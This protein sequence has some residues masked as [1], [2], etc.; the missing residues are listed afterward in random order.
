MATAILRRMDGRKL[1]I[2]YTLNRIKK[3][4][5][6]VPDISIEEKQMK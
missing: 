4:E 5:V 3:V 6:Q 1:R 2:V